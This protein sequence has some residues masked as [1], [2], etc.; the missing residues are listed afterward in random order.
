M[1]PNSHQWMNET[2]SS[3]MTPPMPMPVRWREK[4]KNNQIEWNAFSWRDIETTNL[5]PFS[6][7]GGLLFSF[8]CLADTFAASDFLF[9]HWRIS[10]MITPYNFDYVN[11]FWWGR[12]CIYIYLFA[13]LILLDWIDRQTEYLIDVV[14]VS[15][16][17]F[18]V[19]NFSAANAC[20]AAEFS[21]IAFYL[22]QHQ[23]GNIGGE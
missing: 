9:A 23:W 4:E 3:G 12:W 20:S 19:G 5:L 8:L 13:L 10:L 17:L 1:C 16:R 15:I 18:A 22:K 14:E 6:W 21:E 7:T 11:T 2:I